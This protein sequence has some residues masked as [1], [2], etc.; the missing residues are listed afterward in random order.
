MT[1]NG[2]EVL[3]MELQN[4]ITIKKT[5]LMCVRVW[6]G[7]LPHYVPSTCFKS[8]YVAVILVQKVSQELSG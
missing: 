3:F 1:N 8:P 4:K 6:Q 5:A 2:L 7:N